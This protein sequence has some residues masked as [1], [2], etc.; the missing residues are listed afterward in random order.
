MPLA[1][2][3]DADSKLNTYQKLEPTT[4]KQVRTQETGYGTV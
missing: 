2:K 1:T 4:D 3:A